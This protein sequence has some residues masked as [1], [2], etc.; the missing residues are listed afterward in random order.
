MSIRVAL[1]HK[2][3]Y[4]YDKPINLGPQ[5]VR[6]KPAY[7]ARTPIKSYSLQVHP[8]EHFVNWQQDPF[9]NPIARYVFPKQ[10]TRLSVAVD[11]IA[12]MTVIN[13]FD[14]FIE[15]D[16]NCWPFAYDGPTKHQLAPYLAKGQLT[17][18]LSQWVESF[19]K[20]SDTLIDFLVEINLRT[21]ERVEYLVRM[22]P[23]VQTP[24]ETLQVG[25]GSCRD[26]AWLMV[27]AFRQ[28]GIAARFVSGYLIQL[29]ADQKPLEGPEGP[30]KDF[31]DLHAWAEVYV[32]GAG[33]IGMDPTSGLLA[34]EGHIPLACTPDYSDAAPITGKH[35]ACKV[36]FAHEMSVHRVHE[37]PR[38]TLPYSDAQWAEIMESG[39]RIEK[40][41]VSEDVR[42]TMGGEP[43]FVSAEDMDDPQWQ[44]E[45][46]GPDKRVLS[47]LMLLRLRDRFAPGGLLHYGQGKWYPGESLPRWALTCMWRKDGQPIW[48]DPRWLADEGKDYGFTHDDGRKFVEQ[49]SRRIGISAKLSFPVYEDTF[50]YLWREN[51][52]PIDTDPADPKLEDPNERAMMMRTFQA[53]LSN[54]IGHVLPLRRVWWQA[55]PKW[56]GG[57]WPIRAEK[58][59]LIPG[60]SPVGLRLPLDSLPVASVAPNN[61]YS[62]PLDPTVPRDQLPIPLPREAQQSQGWSAHQ[63]GKIE[64][65]EQSLDAEVEIEELDASTEEV[66]HT[67][68]CVEC[69]HGKLHVFMPPTQRLED[70]LDLLSAIEDVCAE[71]E[72]PVI[73]EG[74]LPPQDHRIELFKVTPDPGVIEVNTQPSASW[75]DLV[76]LTEGLYEDAR[77]CRLGTD[78]FDLDGR[79]T[80]TGGGNHIVLGGSTP[81]DSPFLRRPDL[82][83]SVISFW[84]NHPALSYLFSSRF[85]GPTSQAPRFDESRR[86]AV[87]EMELALSQLPDREQAVAPWMVDRLFRDLLTDLTGNTHRAEIC[88]DKLYSPD[89]STGRLGLVEL[90]GFEMPPHAR[91]SLAQQLLVRGIVA[92]FWER[93]YRRTLKNWGSDLHDRFML[94]NYIWQDLCDVMHELQEFN[95]EFDAQWFLPHF[96]FRF[97]KLGEY[98]CEDG[99]EIVIR[100]AIEP[101]NVMGEEPGISATTRF[102]DSSLERLEIACNNFDDARYRIL[103]NG[104]QVPLHHTDVRNRFVA[105]VRFRAWQPPRCLHPTI[106]VDSPLQFTLVDLRSRRAVGGF[107]YHVSNPNGRTGER[108]PINAVEAESRRAARFETMGFEG[109]LLDIPN[110]PPP[111]GNQPHPV[112]LDLR[113]FT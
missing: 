7:H 61:F 37:D 102:V 36:E 15:D 86:D 28:I 70:Y 8:E 14:F 111:T 3:S 69:R 2:T 25:S 82:L 31:C 10:V 54:P 33:W 67:A 103:C 98:I 68:L 19:P 101:W 110:L 107:T 42:L 88:I 89:S 108:F 85:I 74:Y 71:L 55:Q 57:R 112:T 16:C 94:P 50:H 96:E 1:H 75:S 52:L 38:V 24:E 104:I 109:G 80:G 58:V 39:Q 97:P 4:Q 40:R 45:A 18:L 53:G 72:I 56:I 49:L 23:G 92:A 60:D 27:E 93:P 9:G 105:G 83:G 46:V 6:L 84:N 99:A 87:Y 100:S 30:T 20:S 12:D 41:L 26:S 34:G 76:E 13:P 73:I 47:N 48:Q 106:G 11:L 22:E 79:H 51:R 29:A 77:H 78:K 90:R 66:V 113:R 43:T 59:F 62:Q 32:P 65:N 91:M 63:A 95:V 17:P 64:I 21:K 35:E 44:T 81:N 5:L